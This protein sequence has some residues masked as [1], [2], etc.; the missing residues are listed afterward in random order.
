MQTA[1]VMVNIGGDSGNQVPKTV[2]AAEIAVLIAIHGDDAVS[3][4]EPLGD[5]DRTNR[6]ELNRLRGIYGHATDGEN[7]RIIERLYPGAGARVFE[8]LAELGLPEVLYKP[9]ARASAAPAAAVDPLDHDGDGKKGG[10]KASRKAKK[11]DVEPEPDQ[12]VVPDDETDGVKE[13]ADA[14]KDP[15]FA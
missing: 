12:V 7:N 2:T 3:N 1:Q 14:P 15:L 8:T 5:E 11:A 9:T 6:D 13:M 10:S 4:I